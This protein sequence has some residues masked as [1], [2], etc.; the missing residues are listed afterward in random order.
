MEYIA[1]ASPAR[2]RSA[3]A[4]HRV[5]SCSYLQRCVSGGA[6]RTSSCGICR[7][8]DAITRCGGIATVPAVSVTPAQAAHA[9]QSTNDGSP[10]SMP[11]APVPAV[12]EAPC[13]SGGVHRACPCRDRCASSSSVAPT[14]ATGGGGF[15]VQWPKTVAAS[16]SFFLLLRAAEASPA[17]SVAPA[18]TVHAAL[19]PVAEYI[20][21]YLP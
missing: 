3:R 2:D 14:P 12:C 8:R 19:A 18:P 15:A 21:R 20:S 7:A 5:G 10:L 1:P 4:V 9:E 13:A 17:V 16:L 11:V 6:H